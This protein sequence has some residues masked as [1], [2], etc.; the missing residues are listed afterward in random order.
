V[1]LRITENSVCFVAGRPCSFGEIEQLV[2]VLIGIILFGW[3]LGDLRYKTMA[4]PG[5][6]LRPMLRHVALFVPIP[7]ILWYDSLD[8]NLGLK[9]LAGA[10]GLIAIWDWARLRK[11]TRKVGAQQGKKRIS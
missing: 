9:I 7:A 4:E 2:A 3:L 5:F 10:I 8:S 11:R 6:D 1:P